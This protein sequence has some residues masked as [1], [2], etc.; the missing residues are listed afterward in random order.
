M[1][2]LCFVAAAVLLTACAGGGAPPSLSDSSSLTPQSAFRQTAIVSA[3]SK[4][5]TIA[6][7]CGPN[8]CNNAPIVFHGK[9]AGTIG[10]T[11]GIQYYSKTNFIGGFTFNGI[12]FG[13]F[14]GTFTPGG[15]I[16]IGGLTYFVWNLA[17]TFDN[18]T[19]SVTESWGVRGHSGRG[20]G[21]TSINT[22]GTVTTPLVVPIPSPTPV[23][24]PTPSIDP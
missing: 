5:Y 7:I 18:G 3:G 11:N 24:T 12:H 15:T 13:D 6:H 20:G 8:Y 17:G 16:V 4:T 23:P 14:N 9:Q 10:Y 22:G 1:K 2:T 19:C 21:T